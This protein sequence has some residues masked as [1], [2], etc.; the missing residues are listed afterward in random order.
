MCRVLRAWM[1][2]GLRLLAAALPL[3]CGDRIEASELDGS[4]VCHSNERYFVVERRQDDGYSDFVV[5][6][7]VDSKKLPCIF[8]SDNAHFE[9]KHRDGLHNFLALHKDVL[10]LNQTED[11][12]GGS[13]KLVV[14]DL[15]TKSLAFEPMES[16]EAN[17]DKTGI[18]FWTMSG[19]AAPGNCKKFKEYSEDQGL[20]VIQRKVVFDFASSSIVEQG[21]T[22]CV[23]LHD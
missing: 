15:S 10:I 18:T 22:R 1:I 5:R 13:V 17:L 16:V 6:A 19:D 4:A 23:G 12:I 7:K 9:L 21:Q 3:C 11:P 2:K 14:F 20:P 8:T